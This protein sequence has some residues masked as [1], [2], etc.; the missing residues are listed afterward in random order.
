LFCTVYVDCYNLYTVYGV[1]ARRSCCLSL[2]YFM[3]AV[4]AVV[5]CRVCL[6]YFMDGVDGISSC[7]VGFVKSYM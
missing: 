5:W 6:Q 4:L 2:L 7:C 3:F 1:A